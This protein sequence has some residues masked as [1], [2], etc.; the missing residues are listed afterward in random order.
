LKSRTKVIVPYPAVRKLLVQK[1][2]GEKRENWMMSLQ[3]YEL[4][5]NPAH[6]VRG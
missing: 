4:K 2:M 3:E 6:I 5:I 1:E